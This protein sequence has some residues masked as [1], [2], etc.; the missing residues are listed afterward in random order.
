MAAPTGPTVGPYLDGD[1]LEYVLVIELSQ[2]QI[3]ALINTSDAIYE[4]PGTVV[5]DPMM[6]ALRIT[7]SCQNP[8]VPYP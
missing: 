2:A 1:V 4:M 3:N 8:W 5:F 7:V 6:N